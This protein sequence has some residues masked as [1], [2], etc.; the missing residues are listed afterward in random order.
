[1]R[2][3]GT[4]TEGRPSVPRPAGLK[5][6]TWIKRRPGTRTKG[7][8]LAFRP[9]PFGVPERRIVGAFLGQLASGPS[10]LGELGPGQLARGVGPFGVP[11]RRADR[12]FLG[13]LASEPNQLGELELG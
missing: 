2:R 4:R 9:V 12:A 10:P 13:Q 3:P 7:G 1:M 6:N 5:G 8:R 11:G